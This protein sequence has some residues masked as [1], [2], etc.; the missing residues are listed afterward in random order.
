MVT[1]ADATRIITVTRSEPDPGPLLMRGLAVFPL[2]AGQKVAAPGW[3][4][5]VV[6]GS[7]DDVRTSW[8]AGAN[9]GISC[10]LSGIVG[11]DLDR[12]TS[13][14]VNAGVDGVDQ[15]AAVCERWGF[16]RPVTLEVAT[17]SRGRH[18]IFQVPPGLF[19]GSVSGG[20]SRLGPGIDIRGPGRTLGGYLVG[21]GSVVGGREYIVEV[22]API[23]ILPGWIAALIGRRNR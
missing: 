21:P 2:P 20:T 18:L 17:P 14:G 15:F 7:P 13:G 4:H 23:A 5:T 19:V 6:T 16:P 12:H 9:I 10:R 3:Q 1:T 11:I 22:D 8:P